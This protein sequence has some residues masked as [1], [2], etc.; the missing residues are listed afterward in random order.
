MFFV[1]MFFI[2]TELYD[3]PCFLY[4]FSLMRNGSLF[5]CSECFACSSVSFTC[6]LR[7]R[8]ASAISPLFF[9]LSLLF[10]FDSKYF[11]QS[12]S[13]NGCNGRMFN[14]VEQGCHCIRFLICCRGLLCWCYGSSL[15][16]PVCLCF[17]FHFYF[18]TL[19]TM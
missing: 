1:S 17:G 19:L 11:F 2:L 8:F 15:V 6:S 18:F 9:L 5:I 13:A 14:K 7:I 3:S 4:L 16:F 12:K 10:F